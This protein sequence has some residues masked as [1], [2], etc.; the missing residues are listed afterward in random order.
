MADEKFVEKI[1]SRLAQ[2]LYRYWLEKRGKRAFP[3]RRDID[4]LDLPFALGHLSLVAISDSPRRFHY[5]LVSTGV[6]AD[7]GYEMTGKDVEDIPEPEMRDYVRAFYERALAAR[8]P[9]Y[10][11]GTAVIEGRTWEHKSLALPL[12]TDGAAIDMLLVYRETEVTSS[13]G[14]AAVSTR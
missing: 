14:S 4:P 10:E 9:L 6:T 8:G 1:G 13:P 2:R 11:E 5:R 7:L 12:S 3:S